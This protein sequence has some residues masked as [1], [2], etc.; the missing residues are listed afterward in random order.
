MSE[1]LKNKKLEDLPDDIQ[2]NLTELCECL[3]VIRRAYGK[4][5]TISSGFRSKEDHLRVYREK[6]ITDSKKI[7]MGSKHLSGNACDIADPK[8]ELQKWVKE[9]VELCEKVGL[10]M[11][12]FSATPTWVH[13]QTLSP[14]SK[15]RFFKP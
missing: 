10:W 5:M 1:I 13:F 7:P 11:E 2:E 14:A 4:P 12:D 3:N 6:G 9:N 15:S 8:Q